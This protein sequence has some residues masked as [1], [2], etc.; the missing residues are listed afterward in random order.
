MIHI[1]PVEEYRNRVIE[2]LTTLKDDGIEP[3]TDIDTD[4]ADVIVEAFVKDAVEADAKWIENIPE[5]RHIDK[6]MSGL[7]PFW[8]GT[9][10]D[11]EA[12]SDLMTVEVYDAISQVEH[13]VRLDVFSAIGRDGWIVWD[14][15]INQTGSIYLEKKESYLDTLLACE[16]V[17][18]EV[19]TKSRGVRPKRR[20]W[21]FNRLGVFCERQ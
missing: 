17:N 12:Q 2:S 7:Y 11:Y 21:A 3:C 16:G 6:I 4:A 14:V 18:F 13:E 10:T 20:H 1:L 9:D 8:Q 5:E 19:Q 15:G